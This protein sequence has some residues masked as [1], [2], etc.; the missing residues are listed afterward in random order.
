MHNCIYLYIANR[1]PLL[2][3]FFLYLFKDMCV[4]N[5]YSPIYLSILKKT[6]K[7]FPKHLT[8]HLKELR[9]SIS[10]AVILQAFETLSFMGEKKINPYI[11]VRYIYI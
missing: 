9:C 5:T 1:K 6:L 10:A 11:K 2:S 3:D 8:L 4:L 7:N